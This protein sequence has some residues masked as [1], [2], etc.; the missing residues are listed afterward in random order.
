MR[1]DEDPLESGGTKH[2]RQ[3]CAARVTCNGV[4][5]SVQPP[6]DESPGEPPHSRHSTPA[7]RLLEADHLRALTCEAPANDWQPTVLAL[8]TIVA[9]PACVRQVARNPTQKSR[10]SRHE[11]PRRSPCHKY[12]RGPCGKSLHVERDSDN[13]ALEL[14]CPLRDSPL[15]SQTEV[16]TVTVQPLQFLSLA[17]DRDPACDCRRSQ[18]CREAN[19]AAVL[20]AA[21]SWA[22]C[23]VRRSTSPTSDHCLAN[24]HV[25][26]PCGTV[27][28]R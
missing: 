19:R 4:H 25:P 22:T 16:A 12:L 18:A 10:S 17:E 7:R 26:S 20:R 11:C 14:R 21:S 9:S 1:H 6:S 23:D 24:C 3:C 5:R 8:A 27:G 2:R 28:H 13:A 15:P